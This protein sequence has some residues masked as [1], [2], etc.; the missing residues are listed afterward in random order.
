MGISASHPS[1][2][3]KEQH[4][5]SITYHPDPTVSRCIP[6]TRLRVRLRIAWPNRYDPCDCA[7]PVSVGARVDRTGGAWCA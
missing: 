1:P 7:D 6:N 5:S 4:G 2:N 3:R